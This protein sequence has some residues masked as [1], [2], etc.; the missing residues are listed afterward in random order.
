VDCPIIT[1]QASIGSGAGFKGWA[2]GLARLN[3]CPTGMAVVKIDNGFGS[4]YLAALINRKDKNHD[5]Q[6]LS[7]PRRGVRFGG[8]P[9]TPQEKLQYR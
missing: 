8:A 7:G 9:G 5:R 6:P 1:V 4:W 3:S 2:L